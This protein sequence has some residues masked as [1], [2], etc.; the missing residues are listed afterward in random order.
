[1]PGQSQLRN[2]RN[3]DLAEWTEALLGV[4]AADAD[5]VRTVELRALQTLLIDGK[6]GIRRDFSRSRQCLLCLARRR[7]VAAGSGYHKAKTSCES[8]SAHRYTIEIH[9]P[10]R[11][12]FYFEY[13]K[14]SPRESLPILA[15]TSAILT[16]TLIG[17]TTHRREQ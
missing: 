1:M 3:G 6:A 4:C 13:S 17:S 8:E 14:I 15:Q 10:K 11:S 2:V 16:M 9:V 12:P 7:A 5:P